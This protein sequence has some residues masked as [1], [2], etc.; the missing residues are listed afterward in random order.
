M[1]KLQASSSGLC[2]YINFYY[3]FFYIFHC[4]FLQSSAVQY[5]EKSLTL[6]KI[7]KHFLLPKNIYSMSL[8]NKAPLHYLEGFSLSSEIL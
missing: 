7:L 6:K 2:E 3:Y 5:G 1:L 4:V 8:L